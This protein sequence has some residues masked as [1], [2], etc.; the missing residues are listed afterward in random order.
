MPDYAG[1]YANMVKSGWMTFVLHFPNV[2][3]CLLERVITYFNVYTKLE[4]II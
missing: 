2:I 1:I 3:P 4:V